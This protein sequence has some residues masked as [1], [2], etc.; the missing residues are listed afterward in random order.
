[1]ECIVTSQIILDRE[2]RTSFY[3]SEAFENA[4]RCRSLVDAGGGDHTDALRIFECCS[5]EDDLSGKRVHRIHC[6]HVQDSCLGINVA[7]Y[8][9]RGSYGPF[10]GAAFVISD[11]GGPCHGVQ[12]LRGDAQRGFRTVE[13]AGHGGAEKSPF[14][15]SN[16][17]S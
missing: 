7:E 16:T 1:M 4:V 15:L 11:P 3:L 5:F 14:G 2:V 13:L 12:I 17:S 8:T 10:E 6:E 9:F